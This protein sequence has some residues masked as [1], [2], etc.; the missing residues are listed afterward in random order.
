MRSRPYAQE[1]LRVFNNLA[2]AW[3]VGHP[4]LPT[5]RRPGARCSSSSAPIAACAGASTPTSSRPRPRHTEHPGD[6]G[7]EVALAL[8]GRKGRDF[9]IAAASTCAT[10]KSALPEREVGARPGHREHLHQGVPGPGRQL[11]VPRLQRV[12]L[13][14][15]AEAWSWS[16]CCR[17]RNSPAG[18]AGA[19]RRRRL[20]VRAVAGDAARDAV[21]SH[22]RAGQPR[23]AGIVGDRT[24]RPHD[25]HGRGTSNAKEMVDRLTLY[26]NRVRQAAITSEIIEIVAGAQAT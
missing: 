25:R 1:M 26:M 22:V 10:R 5:T 8:V 14:D 23:A 2:S 4:L 15:L 9:F 12:P 3:T 7:R 19:T 21:P 20:P 13:R 11:G 18:K 17:S 6:P 24:R 16:A